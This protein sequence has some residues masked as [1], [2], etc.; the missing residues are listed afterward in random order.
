MIRNDWLKASLSGATLIL[1]A[2][3]GSHN[4][5]TRQVDLRREFPGTYKG[6][7]NCLTNPPNVD[8]DYSLGLLAI[9]P[10]EDLDKRNHLELSEFLLEGS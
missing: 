3:P 7:K 1:E 5:F 8:F 4:S 10:E 6:Q 9:G 2:Y